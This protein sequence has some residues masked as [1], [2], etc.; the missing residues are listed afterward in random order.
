MNQEY[1]YNKDFLDVKSPRNL[2]PILSQEATKGCG[3]A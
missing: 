3:P 1:E 2:P